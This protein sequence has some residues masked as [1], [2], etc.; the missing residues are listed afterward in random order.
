MRLRFSDSFKR[1]YRRLPVSVQM[2]IDKQLLFLVE[3]ERHPSLKTKKMAGYLSV[4]EGRV[5]GGYRFTFQVDGDLII[6]R[7]AGTHDILRHP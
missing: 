2:L 7:R 4:W 1:D 3:N 6:V 5:S